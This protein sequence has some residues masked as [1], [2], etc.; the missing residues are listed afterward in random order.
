MGSFVHINW[1]ALGIVFGIALAVVVVVTSLF[2][3]GVR[4]LSARGAAREAGSSSGAGGMTVAVVCFAVC[5]AIV[6]YGIYLIGA[7]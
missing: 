7:A 1:S 5:A 2:S 3:I 6:G 4:G